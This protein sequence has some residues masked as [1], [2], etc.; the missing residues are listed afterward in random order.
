MNYL[1]TLFKNKEKR[2]IINKFKSIKRA[3]DFFDK[4]SKSSDE[5]KFSN[6]TENAS[7][8][9]TELG[10]LEKRGI[11]SN[12]SKNT[13]NYSYTCHSFDVTYFCFVYS[14]QHQ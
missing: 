13:S 2:K 11:I 7:K 1:I 5:V 6:K 10:L 9:L 3:L 12:H 14:S 8:S 4:L